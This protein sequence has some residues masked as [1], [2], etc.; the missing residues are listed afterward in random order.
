MNGSEISKL[1]AENSSA[2]RQSISTETGLAAARNII[3]VA[4]RDG[5]KWMLAGGIAVHLYGYLRATADVDFIASKVLSLKSER[6]L[7]FGGESYSTEAGDRTVN[8]D[9]IVRK[10]EYRDFYEQALKDAVSTDDGLWIISPEWL[11]IL[12]HLSSRVKDKL[13]MIWLLQADAI[14]DRT[15][16]IEHVRRVLGDK[17]SLFVIPEFQSEFDYAD[18]LKLRESRSKYSP[19]PSR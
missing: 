9:W 1:V 5:V 8:V 12:K 13:D 14:V 3:P 19:D 2:E 6:S 4:E 10:D 18:L 11:V 15:L 17:A 7:S 16:L